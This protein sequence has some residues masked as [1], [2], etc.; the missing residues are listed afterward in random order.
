MRALSPRRNDYRFLIWAAA[1][2]LIV[3][4]ALT[5]LATSPRARLNV[6]QALSM[7]FFAVV[8]FRLRGP[9]D[10]GPASTPSSSTP[11]LWMPV[12]SVMLAALVWA[13]ALNFYF[14]N[15]DF[16]LLV[17]IRNPSL[18]L[19]YSF[20]WIGHEV[21]YRPLTYAT[22][23]IDHIFWGRTP[24]GFHLTNL[25]MHFASMAG[26]FQMVKR[27]GENRNV[28]AMTAGIF[29]AVP[30]QVE[31]VAW[32]A[33]RFDVLATCL[34]VWTV[35]AYLGF[36]STG[37]VGYYAL[38]LLLCVLAMCSKET[39][40]V[41]PILLT[42]IEW[43]VFRSLPLRR[44]SGFVVVGAMMFAYRWLAL[45]GFGGYRSGSASIVTAVG[46]K[47]LEA[48]FVRGPSQLLLGFNWLQPFGP[49]VVIVALTAGLLMFLALGATMTE[50]RR[51][52][53]LASIAWI[54]VTMIPGHFILMI[55]AGLSN[56][57]IMCLPSVGLALLI[58]QLVSA[59]RGD[60][61]RNLIYASLAALFSLGVLHNLGAWRWTSSIGEETLRRVVEIEPTP[62][63]NTQFVV[64]D[65]PNDIRGVF[66]F[67]TGFTEGLSLVYGRDD[68]Q[69]FR[70][71]APEEGFPQIRLKWTGEP[72]ALIRRE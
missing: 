51:R 42:G 44:I 66:F 70:D 37:R 59:T 29:A 32:M 14:I 30:I 61:M 25:L 38:S 64:S 55:D 16:G 58:G 24:A 50:A 23:A 69:G 8:L 17:A 28:A 20:F 7:C 47:T 21:F 65:M 18:K 6:M 62:P 54:V 31:S 72:P 35:V 48:L 2:A 49:L 57:R 27:L 67:A 3:V 43:I 12:L 36:R 56:S 1:V 5:T 68:V 46:L 4:L 15:D 39:A 71:S 34:T 13:T 9:L 41:L 63:P 19:F 40:F 45:G 53:I 11:A 22:Y 52:V 26:V 60:R 33:G 10:P